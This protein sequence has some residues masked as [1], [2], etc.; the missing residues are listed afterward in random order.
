MAARRTWV[1]VLV[2]TAGVGIFG[3]ICVAGAGVYFVTRHISTEKSTN[4]EAIQAFETVRT[5]FPNQKPLYELDDE[6]RPRVARPPNRIPT[7]SSKPEHL[8]VLA[9]DPEDQR[10]VK[11]SLPFWILRLR[12]KMEVVG[13]EGGFDLERLNLDVEELERIGPAPIF[14]FRDRDG[15][16]VLVWTQ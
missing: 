5:K 14:D 4:A 8:W 2:G 3:L 7:A 9:W 6:Q 11:V 10:L 15:M 1:W 13:K 12:P 16:R